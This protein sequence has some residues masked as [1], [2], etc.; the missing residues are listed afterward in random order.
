MFFF[1]K[2]SPVSPDFPFMGETTHNSTYKPFKTLKTN[3]GPQSRKV[4]E[5]I[6]IRFFT[7]NY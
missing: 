1:I 2:R 3:D 4:I 6:K 5:F 7:M